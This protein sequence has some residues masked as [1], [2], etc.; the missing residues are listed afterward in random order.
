MLDLDHIHGILAEDAERQEHTLNG[1][2]NP[3]QG[4]VHTQFHT[5]IHTRGSLSQLIHL[6]ASYLEMGRTWRTSWK[7]K[8]MSRT[9]RESQKLLSSRWKQGPLSCNLLSQNVSVLFTTPCFKTAFGRL[10][11]NVL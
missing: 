8:D 4:S 9:C 6:L 1:T 10:F 2:T 5:L 11:F 7:L 3:S